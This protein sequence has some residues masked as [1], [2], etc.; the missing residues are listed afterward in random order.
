M[1][2]TRATTSPVATTQF[3]ILLALAD[4]PRYGL[5]IVEEV[6]RRTDGEIR[7]GPG[8]L[9][10]AIKKMV[11]GELIEEVADTSRQGLQDTRR[12]YYRITREGRMALRAEAERLTQWLQVAR[13][14]QVLAE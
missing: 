9:Y 7:L 3:H 2:R 8:T 12:R 1:A 6:A 10:T 14:K 11:E 5:G 4:A 13:D